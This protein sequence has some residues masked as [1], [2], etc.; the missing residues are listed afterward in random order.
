MLM[1]RGIRVSFDLIVEVGKGSE[2]ARRI[3][4]TIEC[5]DEMEIRRTER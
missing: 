4:D 2:W 3:C 1:G 5:H